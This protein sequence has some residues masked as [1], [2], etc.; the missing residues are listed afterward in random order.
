MEVQIFGVKNHKDVRKAERFFK[1]RRIKVHF[2]DFKQRSPSKGELTRFFQKFGEEKLIDRDAKRFHAL[3]F[4]AAY[5]GNER[6]LEIALDEPLILKIPLVRCG[7]NLSV[8]LDE[9]AW[10]EW[11]G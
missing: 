8:G 10:K 1:E 7:K 3:G 6:W 11:L 9:A 4:Q 2:M 5:Y